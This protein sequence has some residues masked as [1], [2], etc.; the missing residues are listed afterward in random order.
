MFF[1]AILISHRALR[2]AE[3]RFLHIK[4]IPHSFMITK[5]WTQRTRI[6]WL[7]AGRIRNSLE[8]KMYIKC[9]D[10]VGTRHNEGQSF[11]V[12]RVMDE[13]HGY[14]DRR[15]RDTWNS[16]T[17]N[18]ESLN[19]RF[20]SF[21]LL[22]LS[23]T[24]FAL[25]V[26]R[27]ESFILVLQRNLNQLMAG[28]YWIYIKIEKKKNDNLFSNSVDFCARAKRVRACEIHMPEY[29]NSRSHTAHSTHSHSCACLSSDVWR[30]NV[31][32]L[33]DIS[34]CGGRLLCVIAQAR[35]HTHNHIKCRT[36]MK[37]LTK[38]VWK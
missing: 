11:H 17:A 19:R 29:F 21:F 23:V 32:R 3:F 24:F 18:G 30:G 6:A 36:Q 35:T 16:K 5:I 10:T 12:H 27:H 38:W 33:H 2:R 37:A 14:G 25:F 13:T 7:I 34:Y 20:L 9:D 28:S 26:N 8:Y 22:L 31:R 4:R 1:F 15:A